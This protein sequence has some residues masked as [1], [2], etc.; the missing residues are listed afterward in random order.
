LVALQTPDYAS[1]KQRNHSSRKQM[2]FLW[3]IKVHDYPV[4]EMKT[5]QKDTMGQ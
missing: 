3:N 1:D 5:P 4:C 2:F